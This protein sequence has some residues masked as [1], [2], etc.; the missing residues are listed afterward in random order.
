MK[1][2]N[3]GSLLKRKL[4]TQ[5]DQAIICNVIRQ[6]GDYPDCH[7]GMLPFVRISHAIYCLQKSTS[8]L[9]ATG[10]TNGMRRVAKILSKLK[11]RVPT[12]GNFSFFSMPL[13]DAK[14]I[15]RFGPNLA[16]GVKVPGRFVKRERTETRKRFGKEVEVKVVDELPVHMTLHYLRPGHWEVQVD[17][18][19]RDFV[20]RLLL[21]TCM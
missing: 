19:H 1:E 7:R 20:V 14:V 3:I 21:G 17:P 9:F 4:L 11:A 2:P 12:H 16:R 5:F 18:A 15:K 13:N 8:M 10:Q 6:F